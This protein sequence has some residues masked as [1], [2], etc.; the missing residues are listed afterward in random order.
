VLTPD[1]TDVRLLRMLVRD[2]R[3]TV[4]ELAERAGVARNTAQAR[5]ERLHAAG[6]LGDNERGVS[7]RALG[8]SVSAV[9]VVQIEH[10]A[11]DGVIAALEANPSVLEV[12]ETVGAADLLVR[13]AARDTT[14]LQTVVHSL[15]EIP[16]VERTQTSVVLTARV[17]YRVTPL[18]EALHSDA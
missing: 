1:R 11:L 5:L 13:V 4:S 8:F 14:D 9:V 7:L 12:E 15:L 3:L 16:G 6:V 17:P 10:R 18:L 2:P